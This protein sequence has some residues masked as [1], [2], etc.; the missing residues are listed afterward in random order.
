M[1]KLLIGAIVGG[2]IIFLWQF[3]SFAALNLHKVAQQYTPKQDTILNVLRANLQE[4][5][6]YMPGVPDNASSDE[7]SKLMEQMVGRDWAMVEYHA[8]YE[9]DM[10][11]NLIRSVLVNILTVFLLGWVLTRGGPLS[12]GT[13]V[14][15]SVF[16]GLMAFFNIAYANFIWYKSP[17][18]WADFTDAIVPWALTG[19]WLG[20]FLNRK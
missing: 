15:A 20:W 5:R 13:I 18:I 4:G 8:K 12:F 3:L 2:I 19:A 17:G 7:R 6:Y 10:V 1:K 16:V 9:N 11:M 14:M